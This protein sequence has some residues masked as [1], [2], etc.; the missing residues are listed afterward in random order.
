MNATDEKLLAL[1][2]TINAHVEL[3][4]DNTVIAARA[5]KLLVEQKRIIAQWSQSWMKAGRYSEIDLELA[6][7]TGLIP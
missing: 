2:D 5:L 4:D 6:D 7:L 3:H 1:V